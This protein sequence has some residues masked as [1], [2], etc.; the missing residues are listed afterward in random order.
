MKGL[1]FSVYVQYNSIIDDGAGK[2][3]FSH[4]IDLNGKRNLDRWLSVVGFHN[5]KHKIK[6][7]R[8]IDIY[9]MGKVQIYS[10]SRIKKMVGREGNPLP[11]F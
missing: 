7:K 11:N 10:E 9:D 5:P 1:G 8:C 3:H 6:V 4:K 2:K